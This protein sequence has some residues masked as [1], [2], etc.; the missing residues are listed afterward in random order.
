MFN[1]A[2]SWNAFADQVIQLTEAISSVD[3]KWKPQDARVLSNEW[4]E[5]VCTHPEAIL[6]AHTFEVRT[7]AGV[8]VYERVTSMTAVGVLLHPD[9]PELERISSRGQ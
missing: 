2:E 8:L 9:A 6:T 5:E 1:L 7:C 3:L 4:V